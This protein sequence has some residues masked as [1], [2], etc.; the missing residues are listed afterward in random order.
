MRSSGVAV[1]VASVAATVV[2]YGN[3]EM[4]FRA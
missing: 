1:E 3:G 2:D 4:I